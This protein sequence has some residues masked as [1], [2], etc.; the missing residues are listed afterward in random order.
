[1]AKYRPF[2]GDGRKKV[3]PIDPPEGTLPMAVT[4]ATGSRLYE[5]F[6]LTGSSSHSGQGATVWVIKA[7]CEANGTPYKIERVGTSSAGGFFVRR[8]K[9][10]GQDECRICG[11]ALDN[12]AD[13]LSTDC[14]GDCLKC[15]ADCGDPDCVE[16]VERIEAAA[17]HVKR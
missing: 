8:L 17:G 3:R 11:R 14:G 7:A 9:V 4:N 15:M 10:A 13:P 12:P 2:D 6:L 1:M 16:A 5:H